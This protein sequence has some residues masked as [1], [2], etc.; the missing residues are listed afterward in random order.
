MID[1][2]PLRALSR[3]VFFTGTLYNRHRATNLSGER[4]SVDDSTR[5]DMEKVVPSTNLT[6]AVSDFGPESST[7]KM[8]LAESFKIMSN[9]ADVTDGILAALEVVG[10]SS[11]VEDALRKF[12]RRLLRCDIIMMLSPMLD[13][14][15]SSPWR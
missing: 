9:S 10:K 11:R 13:S 6:I 3:P 5:S 15:C 12:N 8:D 14:S 2:S 1:V 4:G 7:M